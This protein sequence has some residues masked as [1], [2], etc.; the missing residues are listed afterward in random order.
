MPTLDIPGR[1]Y[2]QS[3]PISQHRRLALLNRFLTGQDI[4]LRTRVAACLLLLYAQP[5]TRLTRLTVHD[6][7]VRDGQVS[8]RLG[9]PP[10]PVPEPFAAMLV[11]LAANRA[12][13]N[14]AANPACPWLFPGG[15][16]GQPLT[17][18]ALLQQIRA[19][20]IPATQTRTAAFRQL[21]LQAPAP[22]V[23]HALGYSQGTATS[24]VIAAGG[25]W[26]R[27]P[28]TRAGD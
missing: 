22:V 7:I 24:H 9:H 6:V 14:T 28:A 3:A 15:R 19:L 17:A 12:N 4:P 23:A 27:Y 10:A 18:G 2:N 25:T 26:N 20:G 11:E 13:M 16:A 1:R 8:V 21:V 5:V